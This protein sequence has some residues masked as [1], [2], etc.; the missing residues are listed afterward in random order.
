MAKRRFL[1]LDEL[2]AFAVDGV[3]SIHQIG[4]A[5]RASINTM[6][7][8]V[9]E[10]GKQTSLDELVIFTHGY[11][12]GIMLGDGAYTLS[13]ESVKKAFAS[14]TTKIAVIRFEGCWIGEAPVDMAEF[15]KLFGAKS[16]SGYTWTCNTAQIEI[17]I[18][19]GITSADLSKFLADYVMWLMPG[20]MSVPAMSSMARQRDAKASLP[21]MW[22]RYD[23]NSDPGAAPYVDKNYAKLG[24]HT[25]AARTQATER[26]VAIAKAVNSSD[27]IPPFEYVTVV[28]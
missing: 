6:D 15:G 22:Y 23:L 5:D 14:T 24:R 13:D 21:M 4:H 8:L 18:P 7:D 26:S 9:K 12:G 3:A 20:T 19:Q 17:G 11:S 27:P 1:Y 10:I 28:L 25:Y 2:P 16:V